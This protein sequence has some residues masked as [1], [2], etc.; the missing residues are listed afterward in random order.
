[1]LSCITKC[2]HTPGYKVMNHVRLNQ[3][4]LY[5]FVRSSS[6]FKLTKLN[7]KSYKYH[8]KAAQYELTTPIFIMEQ[9][10]PLSLKCEP[11]STNLENQ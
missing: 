10:I 11:T 9:Y 6:Q 5:I 1:M 7:W 4:G 3:A 8:R 2:F